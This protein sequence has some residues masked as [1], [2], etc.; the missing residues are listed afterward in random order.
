METP[1]DSESLPYDLEGEGQVSFYLCGILLTAA[2]TSRR[3]AASGRCAA[4]PERRPLQPQ[5]HAGLSERFWFCVGSRPGWTGSAGA[6]G[7]GGQAGHQ[8]ALFLHWG[9]PS[10]ELGQH[11]C[12]GAV[13]QGSIPRRYHMTL[14]WRSPGRYLEITFAL[15]LSGYQGDGMNDIIVFSSCF[16]PANSLENYQYVMDH[17]FR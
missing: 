16:L 8:M 2:M 14:T 10:G 13:P 5:V 9:A 7:H 3:P 11:E 6:G 1:S 15:S 12:P 4:A 17:L